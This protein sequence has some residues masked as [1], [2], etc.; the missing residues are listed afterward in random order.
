M[1]SDDKTLSAVDVETVADER[2]GK[3]VGTAGPGA[4]PTLADTVRGV[5]RTHP[6]SADAPAER[7]QEQR[8]LGRGGMGRVVEARDRMLGRRVAIKHLLGDGTGILRQRFDVEALVTA[9]L[10]HPGIPTVYERATGTGGLPYYTMRLVE[11]QTFTRLLREAATFEDRMRLLPIIV[12]VA[13]TL[14]FAHERGVIHRDV[15][16]DNVV[17]GPHGDA[18]L[19][20]WGIAKVRGLADAKADD[21]TVMTALGASHDGALTV[22]G[23]ILGTPAYM[24]PEQAKGEIASVDERTDVFALGAMLYHLLT[25]HAPYRGPTIVDVLGAARSATPQAIDLAAPTAPDGLRAIVRRAMAAQSGD[26]FAS[27]GEFAAAL[28]TFMASAVARP[29]ST[30]IERFIAATSWFGF[31]ACL[32]IAAAVWKFTPTFEEMGYAGWVTL[33][34]FVVGLVLNVVEW[35]TY[36]RHRLLGLGLAM[37]AMTGISAV[38][39]GLVGLMSVFAYLSDPAK[40]KDT[41]QYLHFLAIGGREALGNVPFGLTFALVQAMILAFAWRRQVSR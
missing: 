9:Q 30:G 36:G 13:Q 18:V 2:F 15:K 28:E 29:A 38:S 4:Q 1:P 5:M 19:L 25:G 40:V 22:H 31:V 39:G 41:S 10:D 14:A 27:A 6:Q 16:P 26:R 24:A 33:A 8:E 12:R 17:V 21:E 3:R 23:S 20:D 32:L 11:G 34:C 35:A 37:T 7:Y